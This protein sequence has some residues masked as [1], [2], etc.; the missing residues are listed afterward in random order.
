MINKER[1]DTL[2]NPE[3]NVYGRNLFILSDLIKQENLIW[4]RPEVLDY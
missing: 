2:T 3:I 1:S 4:I